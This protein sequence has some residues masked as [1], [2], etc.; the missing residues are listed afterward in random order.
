MLISGVANNGTI[1]ALDGM[2]TFLS[3]RLE[4]IAENVA[5]ADTPDYRTKQLD[6]RAFQQ[7]MGKAMQA[8]R[9]RPGTPLEIRG[10]RQFRQDAA[11]RLIVTPTQRPAENILFHD[12]SDLSIERQM[13]DLAETQMMHQAMVELLRGKYEALK[14]AIRGRIA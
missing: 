11:G 4:M 9:E 14:T 5:N 8:R 3:A 2:L 12:G 1:P 6:A 7:E 13:A 10:T